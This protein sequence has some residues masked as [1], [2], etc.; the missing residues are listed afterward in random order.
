MVPVEIL[1]HDQTDNGVAKILEAL[2]GGEVRVRVFIQIRSTH[3]GLFEKVR[4][5][6]RQAKSRL[7]TTG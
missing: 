5:V 1:G 4:V 2:V 3:E 6:K 7:G